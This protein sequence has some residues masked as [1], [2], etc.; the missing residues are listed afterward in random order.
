MIRVL[1][2]GDSAL[3]RAGLEAV[4]RRAGKTLALAGST[5]ALATVVR[6]A[7][8]YEPDV[9]LLSLGPADEERLDLI[10]SLAGRTGPGGRAGSEPGSSAPAV[11]VLVE[12]DEAALARDALR[13]GARAVLPGDATAEEIVAAVVAA[14]TGLVALRPEA[15]E[16][17][18]AGPRRDLPSRLPRPGS[19]DGF[20]EEALTPREL[21]VFA[22]LAEGLG[23]K[24]IAGR[25]RISEHT[26]KFH[27]ASI[28]GK[29]GA[30]SRTEAV[31]LGVRRGL[32]ML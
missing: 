26:V 11:V 3:V 23:N 24:E 32:I 31:A 13:A 1:V 28:L 9:V 15:V 19:A 8:D 6:D 2:A 12:G 30:G 25:L 22:L 7:G 17:L 10:S 14:S 18:I 21:E 16:P 27:V 29:L 5:A 4:V 20:G